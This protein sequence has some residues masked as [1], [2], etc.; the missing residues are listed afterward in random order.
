MGANFAMPKGVSQRPD[1]RYMARFQ[2]NGE[3]YCLY[4]NEIDKLLERVSD[5]KYE[6][7]HGVYSKESNITVDKWFEKWIEEY[8]LKPALIAGFFLTLIIFK[9]QGVM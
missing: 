2:Y 4:D 7:K 8:K 9:G 6:V 3:K 5:L 1:G